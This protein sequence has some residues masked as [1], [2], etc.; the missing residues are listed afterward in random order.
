MFNQTNKKNLPFMTEQAKGDIKKQSSTKLHTPMGPNLVNTKKSIDS[1]ILSSDY[2]M[3]ANNIDI[4]DSK[5]FARIR[6]FLK[7][8]IGKTFNTQALKIA[9]NDCE[10]RIASVMAA[11]YDVVLDDEMI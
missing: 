3:N 7:T 11:Y 2:D 5:Y 4:S 6:G 10:D 9:L 8:P 1:K